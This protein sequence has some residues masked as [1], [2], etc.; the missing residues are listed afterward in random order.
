MNLIEILSNE[1]KRK[2][3]KT[4]LDYPNRRWTISELEITSKAPH[5][6]TWRTVKEL[7]RM[8]ILTISPVGKRVKIIELV[9]GSPLIEHIKQILRIETLPHKEIANKFASE[10]K[11][12]S[13]IYSCILFGS[14]VRGTA[15]PE[16]DIDI[17][18]IDKRKTYR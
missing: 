10:I 2:V 16:S 14:V 6:T 5:A 11:K 8:K 13:Q 4:L 7:E 18:I 12:F 1:N 17:L 3:V 15:K 9:Q